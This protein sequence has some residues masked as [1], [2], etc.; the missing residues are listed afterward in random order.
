VVAPSTETVPCARVTTP[1]SGAP[2]G[3]SGAD[4]DPPDPCAAPDAIA[5]PAPP[6]PV[7]GAPPSGCERTS[8][9]TAATA[10]IGVAISATRDQRRRVI[11]FICRVRS[12]SRRSDE[13]AQ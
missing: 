10:A 1:A 7:A 6:W 2:I 4:P 8:I 5:P 9:A 13:V 11:A 12:F 3:A